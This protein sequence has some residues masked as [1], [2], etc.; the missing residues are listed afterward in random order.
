[1]V[2]PI[3][4]AAAGA[5]AVTIISWALTRRLLVA[6]WIGIV[7]VSW[8]LGRQLAL[9]PI[10][11]GL[12]VV[13]FH[14]LARWRGWAPRSLPPG[15]V[16]GPPLALCGL[17]IYQ[18]AAGGIIA[19][20]DFDFGRPAPAAAASEGNLTSMYVLLLDGYP[21]ADELLDAFEYDNA[22]FIDELDRLGFQV[23]A[24]ATSTFGGTSWTLASTMLH[25]P[26]ELEPYADIDSTPDLW[27]TLRELR[28]SYLVNVPMM[29][30]LRDAGYRLEY[31]AAGVD[32]S[33]WRGWDETHDSGHISDTEALLIQRSPL[34]HQLGSWVMDQ[35]RS[36]V[37]DSLEAWVASSKDGR[38]KVSFAHVMP[39]HA[40]LLWGPDEVGLMPRDCWFAR[41]CSMY[42]VIAEQLGFSRQEYGEH[43]GWQIDAVNRRVTEAVRQITE[44]D[45]DAIVVVMSDH[46][47]RYQPHSPERFHTFLATRIPHHPDL[48]SSDP[49]PDGLF[50][51]LFESVTQ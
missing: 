7:I 23:H 18:L 44:A 12:G 14:L 8:V 51:R 31:T 24:D 16:L 2:R 46:G 30:R 25:E 39:P 33:E 45:A 32:L 36:R 27:A 26:N 41:G 38:Q 34:A 4:V 47:A 21:R 28:R 15:L 1:M 37:D 29:D 5:T 3:F 48:M 49:G 10:G 17:A 42:T 13:A 22:P 43:L 11:V 6:A 9:L 19:P 40:P 50:V 20:D 35:L